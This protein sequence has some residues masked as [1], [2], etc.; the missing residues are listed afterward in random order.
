MRNKI[1]MS[2][3]MDEWYQGRWA[4]GSDN[5]IF[6]S[7][8]DFFK[9]HYND[10]KPIGE[11]IK[12]TEYILKLFEKNNIKA[13]FFFTGEIAEYY[14]ELVEK[15]SGLGYEI[16]SHN[17]VHKDYDDTNLDEFK[18]HLKKSK[19]ILSKL[20]NQKIIG[21]RAPN[22]VVSNNHIRELIA[23]GFKYDSSVTPTRPLFGQFGN[24]TKCPVNPYRLK[25]DSY[26]EGK[27]ELWEFPWAHF[28]VLKLPSGSGITTRMFGLHYAVISLKNALRTGHTSYY[29]HP[30]EIEESPNVKSY[31]SLH[32]TLYMRNLGKT[33]LKRLK[34][35][36]NKFKGQFISGEELLELETDNEIK[37]RKG[38]KFSL[39]TL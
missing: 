8:K 18:I 3:D 32:A 37:T 27:S 30:Y 17:F 10:D 36:I 14:P 28:P 38:G 2:V 1:M 39:R 5:S 9:S 29:F 31:K 33:Y 22:S 34:A 4:T 20:S 11:I 25:E 24:F 15:I 6:P 16:G 13:T 35:I 12:P 19:R 7:V 26:S 21:Y 23:N